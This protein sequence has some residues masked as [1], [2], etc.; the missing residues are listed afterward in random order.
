MKIVRFR[1]KYKKIAVNI[2]YFQHDIKQSNS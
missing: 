2:Q 1:Y